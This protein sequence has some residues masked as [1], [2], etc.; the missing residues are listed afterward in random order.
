MFKHKTIVM[1]R[2][3]TCLHN[4]HYK[5][6][7]MPTF[8]TRC[9]KTSSGRSLPPHPALLHRL[10]IP[11]KQRICNF[12]LFLMN[13]VTVCV[14]KLFYRTVIIIYFNL[15]FW[16]RK[17]TVEIRFKQR[18]PPRFNLNFKRGYISFGL[19]MQT[20]VTCLNSSILIA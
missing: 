14:P 1:L 17:K 13:I 4:L 20:C 16:K 11:K 8:R 3:I 5:K 19:V 6:G 9:I 12:C 7:L 10:H 15:I 2:V 18:R